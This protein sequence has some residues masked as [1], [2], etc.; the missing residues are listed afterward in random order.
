MVN[1]DA[2][3]SQIPTP[4][5]T[6]TPAASHKRKIGLMLAGGLIGMNAYY[7]PIKKDVFIQRAF[8]ITKNNADEK[9]AVLKGIAEEVADNNISTESKMILQDM[10]L[11]EDI[12]AIT[13]KCT[14]LDKKVSDPTSVKSLKESFNRNFKNYKKNP[15]SMDSTCAEAFRA[16]KRNKFRW[17]VGIGAAIGLALG[18]MTSRD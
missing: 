17:G 1:Y 7:L 10:G 3:V 16:I 18:L 9:I 5:Y 13:N 4:Y 11:P 8:D 2:Q 6:S 14:E 12:T 15:A